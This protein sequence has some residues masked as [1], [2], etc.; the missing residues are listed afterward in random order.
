MTSYL[1][2][3]TVPAVNL[4]CRFYNKTGCFGVIMFFLYFW[5]YHLLVN[6]ELYML[7]DVNDPYS[8][9]DVASGRFVSPD[10]VKVWRNKRRLSER[11]RRLQSQVIVWWCHCIHHTRRL[12]G[13]TRASVGGDGCPPRSTSK[14]T[15]EAIATRSHAD[16]PLRNSSEIFILQL[17]TADYWPFIAL[18]PRIKRLSYREI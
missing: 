8:L 7:N 6:K 11:R 4:S 17:H 14:C 2:H 1:N 10:V 9:P 15:T 18:Q 13:I 16:L 3:A 5:F 12:S